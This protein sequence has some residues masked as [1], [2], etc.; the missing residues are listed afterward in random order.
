LNNFSILKRSIFMQGKTILTNLAMFLLT[1]AAWAVDPPPADV[2]IENGMPQTQAFQMQFQT[3]PGATMNRQVLIGGPSAGMQAVATARLPGEYWLGIE[4]YSVMPV[5]RVHLNLPENQGLVVSNVVPESPAAKAGIESNDIVLQAGEKKVANVSELAE[6]VESAKETP[7]KLEIIHAG[8]PKSIE[9]TPA[10]RPQNVMFRQEGAPAD[11][12][13]IEQWMQKMQNGEPSAPPGQFHFRVFQP[14]AILPPGAPIHPPM[15]GNMSI[16]VNRNGN[17]PAQITVKWNDKN[18]E[19]TENELDKLPPEVRPHVERMLG[20]GKFQVMTFGGSGGAAGVSAEAL[21]FT[22]PAPPPGMP[23]AAGPQMQ[24]QPF[25]SL[26]QRLEE[27][28]RKI[29]QIQKELQKQHGEQTPP[30]P[31]TDTP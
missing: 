7:L 4:C 26:E 29:D 5:L 23:G 16:N 10:K 9:A 3:M 11:L 25:R 22:V 24:V 27:M 17:Q 6:A 31:E 15:P 12:K 20:R 18:Y 1:G 28:N 2:L 13:E 21:D 19:T 14:G 30:A 8:K